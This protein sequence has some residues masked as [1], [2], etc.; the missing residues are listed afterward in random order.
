M[1]VNRRRRPLTLALV[2]AAALAG[3][4]AGAAA[5][6]PALNL[7]ATAA[8]AANDGPLT[9]ELTR[10][11]TEAERAPLVTALS[12]PTPAPASAPPAGAAAGRAGRA[13][14]GGRRS[15]AGPAGAPD[16]RDQGRADRG[17][18]VGRPASPATRSSTRGAGQPLAAARA[19]SSSPIAGW[20]RIRRTG[21]R[22]R[23]DRATRN[24]RCS[25]CASMR[26]ALVTASPR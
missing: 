4:A 20:G 19:S 5:D 12:A 18:R 26:T 24:S 25:S 3:P 17:L 22:R 11:S 9:I 14:R 8:P 21:P 2:M 15:A 7:R 13:G 6:G 16:H 10:W 23:A 1:T